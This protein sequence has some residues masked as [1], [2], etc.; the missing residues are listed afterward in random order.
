MNTITP[1]YT[2]NLTDPLDRVGK[3]STITESMGP[4]S[5]RTTLHS[6]HRSCPIPIIEGGCELIL[7][8]QY[9]DRLRDRLRLDLYR[10]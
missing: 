1:E 7:A 10:R 3:H 5:R 4:K 8:R 6:T 9:A 2:E